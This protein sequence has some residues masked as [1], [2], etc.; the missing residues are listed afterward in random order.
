MTYSQ[1]D[2]VPEEDDWVIDEEDEIWE[3][4]EIELSEDDGFDSDWMIEEEV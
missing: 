4:D 3:E 1:F 2:E